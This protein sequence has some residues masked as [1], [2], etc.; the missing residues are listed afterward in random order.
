MLNPVQNGGV[1]SPSGFKAAGA[2]CGL[3]RPGDTRPDLALIFSET[4]A[5]AAAMF[6][7][8]RVQAAPVIVSKENLANQRAQAV[9]ANAGVANACTG[10]Q[11]IDA[12]K[13]MA[14][15]TAG[16]LGLSPSDVV[17]ASTGVIGQQLPMEKIESGIMAAA[18]ALSREGGASAALAITTTDTCPKEVAMQISAGGHVVTIGGMAKGSGMIRPQ[19]ATMLCFLTTD[20]A[21]EGDAL[22]EALRH[23]VEQSFNM[24]TVDNDTS[25][26]DCVVVLAN[27]AACNPVI[28]KGTGEFQLFL[29]A[30]V[31]VCSSLAQSIA[32]DGEGAT[33]LLE[34]AVQGAPTVE[35]AR[36]AALTVAGSNLVKAAV[37]GADANWGRIMAALGY[38][39]ANFDPGSVDISLGPLKLVSKGQG[40]G[41]DEGLA[42]TLLEADTVKIDIN[43]NSGWHR[44]VAWGCDLSYDYVRINGSY[45]S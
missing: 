4:P 24:I 15:L 2:A 33:K 29:K 26:N 17:V 6:T 42:R 14:E 25:T 30:M 22:E 40:A 39:G 7:T 1:T 37:F 18:T 20:A 36:R 16:L 28:K 45:R 9:V 44:A 43:L 23:A 8:N 41:F 21:I 19:M 13:G 32:R 35:E 38:S 10:Q 34:I 12:A 5:V 3:R 27:G 31:E 11:G